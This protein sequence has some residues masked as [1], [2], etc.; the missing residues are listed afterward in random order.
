MAVRE[1]CRHYARRTTPTGE[2]LES[3]RIGVNETDPFACPPDCLFFEVRAI[4][5]AGW[6]V[7]DS[8]DEPRDR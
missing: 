1:D 4:S 5:S 8:G 3:C 7:P 2:R 6:Q